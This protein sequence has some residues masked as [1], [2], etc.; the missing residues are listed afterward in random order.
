[1]DIQEPEGKNNRH[2]SAKLQQNRPFATIFENQLQKDKPQNL[3]FVV[4]CVLFTHSF[5]NFFRFFAPIIALKAEK[6]KMKIK[7]WHN[8]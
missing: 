2:N 6:G 3:R 5:T 7:I 4:F 1:M 8:K